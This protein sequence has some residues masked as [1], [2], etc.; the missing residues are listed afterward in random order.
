MGLNVIGIDLSQEAREEAIAQGA[1]YVFDPR[2]DK[3]YVQKVKEITGKGCHAA[4]NFTNSLDAYAAMAD[5]LRVNGILMVVGIP[6]RPL[7]FQG[8]D[9]SLGKY[10]IK[11]SNNGTRK[12]LER[13]VAFSHAHGI[14]PHVEFYKLDQIEEMIGI[15]RNGKQRGR[16]AVAFDQE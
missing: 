1:D 15:M 9:V 7:S 5:T 16:M 12:V 13:C 2:S 4:I 8:I 3:E 14:A 11:G 6:L 10:R